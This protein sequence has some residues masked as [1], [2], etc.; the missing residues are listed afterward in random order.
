MNNNNQSVCFTLFN[1]TVNYEK[2]IEE[3]ISTGNIPI[4][5]YSIDLTKDVLEDYI[6]GFTLQAAIDLLEQQIEYENYIGAAFMRDLIEEIKL[7][8]NEKSPE[9]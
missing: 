9:Y 1:E 3:T 6:N 5:K 4:L 2:F 8:I 7:E